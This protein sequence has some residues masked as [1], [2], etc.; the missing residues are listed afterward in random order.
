MRLLGY[1]LLLTALK[2]PGIDRLTVIQDVRHLDVTVS[3][4]ITTQF[5]S[6]ASAI[7]AANLGVSGYLTKPFMVPKV[8]SVARARPWRLR[9]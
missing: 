4:V 3:T 6:E 1:D 2:M 8:L 9:A 7:E 5:S